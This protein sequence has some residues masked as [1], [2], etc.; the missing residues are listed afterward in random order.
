LSTGKP[1]QGFVMGVQNQSTESTRWIIVNAVPEFNGSSKKPYRVYATFDDITELMESQHNLQVMSDR[2]D[3]AVRIA[4]IAWWDWHIPEN[5]VRVSEFKAHVIGYE[6]KEVGRELDFWTS[7][8]HPE[9]FDRVMGAME[10]YLKGEADEYRVEYRLKTKDGDFVALADRGEIIE[11]GE[12]GAPLR[13]F[14][15]V[16]KRS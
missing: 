6:S 9:D 2:L 7:R 16:E 10:Q 8:I 13:L 14:G 4:G 12:D 11:R 3:V 5:E 15:T 1:V